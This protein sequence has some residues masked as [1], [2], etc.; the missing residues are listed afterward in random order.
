M[1]EDERFTARV[2]GARMVG[3]RRA[4]ELTRHESWQLLAGVSLGRIVFTRHAMPAVRPVNHVVDEDKIII[5]SHLGA[6]IVSRAGAVDG[7]VVCY[8]ADDLDP[9]EHTGW[10]VIVTGLARL[11][12]DPAAISRYGRLLEPWVDTTM[13]YVIAIEARDVTGLRLVSWCPLTR[14]GQAGERRR[15]AMRLMSSASPGFPAAGYVAGTSK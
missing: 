2:S 9:V 15:P 3:V 4:V 13:D 10:S 6:Q 1:A 8:E 7:V 5:R 14:R 12:T 11:V